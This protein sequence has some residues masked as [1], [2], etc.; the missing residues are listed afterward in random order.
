[1]ACTITIS[2]RG[3][4]CRDA[5][6]GVKRAWIGTFADGI[7]GNPTAGA[8]TDSTAAKIVY[9]FDLVKNASQL[10]QT[11]NAEV[12]TGSVFY[13]Q[14]F[15]CTIPK[16]EAGVNAEIADLVKGHLIVIVETLNG[17][18]V[19]L[20][21]TNGCLVTGGTFVTGTNPGDLYGYTLT[22]TAEEK[23]PAP[24]LTGTQTLL[25]FTAGN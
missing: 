25:T 13:S 3:I 14:V 5:I 10:T 20:G 24:F 6:G 16:M 7:F 21:H 15:E 12:A 1:M 22:F 4:P 8:L 19:I 11:I 18:K 17:D 2:G 23:I 9:G